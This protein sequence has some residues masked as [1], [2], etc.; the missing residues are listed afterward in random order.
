M[1]LISGSVFKNP[2]NC[3]QSSSLNPEA[4][5]NCAAGTAY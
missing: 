2:I 3:L 5:E 1:P 4:P